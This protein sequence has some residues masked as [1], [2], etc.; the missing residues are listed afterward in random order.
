MN[1]VNIAG[2]CRISVDEEL[3]KDNVS[4]ENQ[5]SIIR[6]F[7]DEKFPG[8]NLHFFVDRDRSGYTFEQRESYKEM[9]S[10][11][12]S[13]EIPIMIIK[14]FSRFSRRNSR[15]LVELEDLRDR[16]VRIISI[17]DNIDF[18]NDDDW[19]KIQF[20]FLVNEMPVTDASKK[21]RSVIKNRQKDGKW[22]CVAPYGYVINKNSEFEIIPEEAE[23]I[24]KIF[25]LY[26]NGWGY[27]KIANYL[28]DNNVPTPKM[29][30]QIREELNGDDENHVSKKYWVV[31]SLYKIIGN[32]FY[33]G[34]LRQGKYTRKKIN[35]KDI[36]VD[37][38]DHIVIKNHHPGII[39][40]QLFNLAMSLKDTRTKTNYRGYKKNDNTYSGLLR[41]GD[42]GSPMFAYSREDLKHSY[43]CGAYNARGLKGCTAH[44]I[45]SEKLDEI[46][47]AYIT[48]I[49]DN[50][51]DFI[52]RLDKEIANV[53][54]QTIGNGERIKLLENGLNDAYNELKE[55]K[56]QRV[57][58]V[59]KVP[60]S[61]D[62]IAEIYDQLESDILAKIEAVKS[63][64]NTLIQLDKDAESA[65]KSAHT[66]M[67]I[68]NKI[69]AKDH[70]SRA[71]IH[72]IVSK[73]VVF[74]NRIEIFLKSDLD[75]IM[76][77][78]GPNPIQCTVQ[79]SKNHVPKRY[80][81]NVIREGDP[82]EITLENKQAML[83]GIIEVANRMGN[84][85][86]Y[87]D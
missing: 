62:I 80:T 17:N 70:L 37:K 64:I 68:F 41:C 23:I 74:E 32:D 35:G 5:K 58:E 30:E 83:I 26:C 31:S 34:T 4:I 53:D 76:R 54:N 60:G 19:L 75:Y 20:Q 67:D 82:L 45:Q 63:Q 72:S 52:D 39:S 9:R 66:A 46:L 47:K 71:D 40:E 25:E 18:P 16:G 38:S 15:G 57:K 79:Q 21:I 49:R 78:T 44:R 73:I 43:I 8:S 69:L 55:T 81:L 36:P 56:R 59:I 6:S 27:K 2:Y 7:V 28:N 12:V 84:T 1:A 22:I 29:S 42:C 10:K 24:K 86:L 87:D 48:I 14:D 33:I 51:Q 61:E 85:N 11:L 50:S 3:N 77:S 13:G 65:K